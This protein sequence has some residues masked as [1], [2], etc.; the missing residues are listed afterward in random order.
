MSDA[1]VRR[2]CYSHGEIPHRG[3]VECH[4][5]A[6]ELY[7]SATAKLEVYKGHMV[8]YQLDCARDAWAATSAKENS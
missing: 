1:V 6:L 5:R 3:C 4:D 2:G 8:R 7:E